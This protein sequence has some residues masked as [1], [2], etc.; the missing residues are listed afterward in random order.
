MQLSLS[1]TASFAMPL[2]MSL[3]KLLD[4]PLAMPLL[5]SLFMPSTILCSVYVL[6]MALAIE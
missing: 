4:M 3:A 6:I 2:A 5:F 1:L